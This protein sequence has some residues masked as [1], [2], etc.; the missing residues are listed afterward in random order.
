LESLGGQIK[1][2]SRTR[3]GE[4]GGW[5]NWSISPDGKQTAVTGSDQL[6]DKV[7]VLD[8][9]VRSEKDLTLPTTVRVLYGLCWSADGHAL[10]TTGHTDYVSLILRLELLSGKSQIL[11]SEN[12]YHFAFQPRIAPD[13][14]HLAYSQMSVDSNAFLLENF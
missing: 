9:G 11:L 1:E 8:L 3:I 14:R 4:P 13:G 7:R 10:Y 6:H 2:L 5:F 12:G